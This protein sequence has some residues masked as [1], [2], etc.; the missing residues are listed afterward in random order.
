MKE[1]KIQEPDTSEFAFSFI[2]GQISK[3]KKDDVLAL[4]KYTPCKHKKN[5]RRSLEV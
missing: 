3:K 4:L 2:K 1:I 5:L